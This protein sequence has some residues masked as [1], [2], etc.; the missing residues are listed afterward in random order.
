MKAIF[1]DEQLF[2]L[3]FLLFLID[4]FMFFIFMFFYF[5]LKRFLNLPWDEIIEGIERARK[6]VAEL[7]RLKGGSSESK[8]RLDGK[9]VKD[10]VIT[11]YKKG[12]S[13]KEIA[14]R[15]SLSEGEVELIIATHKMGR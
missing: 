9:K 6:L 5:R 10:S 1:T 14:R 3:L 4:V 12:V 2:W 13:I 8:K 7:E 11:L 15:L